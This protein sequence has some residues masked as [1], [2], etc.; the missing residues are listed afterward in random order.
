[1]VQQIAGRLRVS[2]GCATRPRDSPLTGASMSWISMTTDSVADRIGRRLDVKL[3][4][5]A[6]YR[7]LEAR[8]CKPCS[9]VVCWTT[10][11]KK[12]SV[13]VG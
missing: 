10:G 4:G 5:V 12:T 3:S 13:I 9:S 6:L 2:R 8:Y 1:M 7:M 11:R